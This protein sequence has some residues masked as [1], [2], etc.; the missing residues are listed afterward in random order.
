MADILTAIRFADLLPAA[1]THAKMIVASTLASAAAGTQ[2]ES[3]RII[4][5]LAKESGGKTEATVWFDGA[6][7]PIASAARVNAMLSDA[8]ASDDSD[9]RNVA[10]IGTCITAV[11]M[12]LAER[13][14][15]SGS[16]LLT[17]MVAGYEA[18][19]RIGEALA[20][21]TSVAGGIGAI[22]GAVGRGF[23]ASATV[24]F[25]G[26]ATAGHL[27]KLTPEQMSHAIGAVATTVGGLSISTNSWAREYH[28]GNAA[29]T[30]IN[31]ALAASRGFTVNPDML[32]ANA[33]FLAIFGGGSPNVSA[34]TRPINGD[35]Q[36][37]RYLA[38]KLVPGAHAL[39]PAVEAAVA[40]ARESQVRPDDIEHVYVAGPQSSLAAG[41][42]PKDV[43]EAIHSLPYYI[44]SGI[45]DREF[46]WRHTDPKL[47]E[48]PEIAKL[49]SLVAA[50]PTPPAIRYQWNWGATVTIVT[51]QGARIQKTVDAPRGS[52]P[53]GIEWS[54]VEAKY[55]ALWPQSKL[56]IG[57]AAAALD[58]IHNLDKLP[59]I[60]KLTGNLQ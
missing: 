34:L 51:K 3:A 52:A 39:H 13:A 8:A 1:T 50:D 14:G 54:D 38:I 26:V 17:A 37:A 46:T 6:R 28:A 42:K 23:H 45:I 32:D 29:T 11:G 5:T 60:T 53:R 2:L 7:L 19:G 35:F 31:A 30:A 15:S 49:I 59:R 41:A 43:V 12:A 48:R 16:E 33:G 57:K 55:Q 22:G 44:A 40:A 36:I 27:L 10:H 18:G 56:P 20:A 4:R 58:M 25:A 24:A 9:L 47:F 21:S